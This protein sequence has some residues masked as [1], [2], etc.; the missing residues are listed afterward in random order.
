MRPQQYDIRSNFNIPISYQKKLKK[1]F[2]IIVSNKDKVCQRIDLNDD[3][4]FFSDKPT[5]SQF[6]DIKCALCMQ[7]NDMDVSF[8]LNEIYKKTKIPIGMGPL[9]SYFVTKWKHT[10]HTNR[11]LL[12]GPIKS[13]E[14][15]KSSFTR[16]CRYICLFLKRK[17]GIAKHVQYVDW[18]PKPKQNNIWKT[19]F[20]NRI[21][22]HIPGT[23]N[24]HLFKF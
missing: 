22:G 8:E 11:S 5:L 10:I 16:D 3:E 15:G 18:T 21:T 7:T 24:R 12:I 14:S 9:S 2:Y 13:T 6:D 20:K 23:R 19:K 17:F 4:I 1:G